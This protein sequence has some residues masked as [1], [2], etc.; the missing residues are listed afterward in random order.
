MRLYW[1]VRSKLRLWFGIE[2]M[3]GLVLFCSC[4][5]PAPV[6]TIEIAPAATVVAVIPASTPV[7]LA[8]VDAVPVQETRAPGATPAPEAMKVQQS[9]E[10]IE[11]EAPQAEAEVPPAAVA[12]MPAPT[13]TLAPTAAPA[14]QQQAFDLFS[15]QNA[16]ELGAIMRVKIPRALLDEG[17]SPVAEYRVNITHTSKDLF[18]CVV[19]VINTDGGANDT[20]VPL[21][22][23][24]HTGQSCKL[25]DFFVKS[26]LS[27]K[28]LLPDLVTEQAQNKNL[29]LLCEVPPVGEDQPFYIKDG[30]I[31]LLYRPYEIT[32]YEAGTPQFVLRE[33]DIAPYLSGAYGIGG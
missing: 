1:V 6:D 9:E 20:L 19:E 4:A 3:L 33:K 15:L 21:T 2:L 16:V 31:V 17:I 30:K 5:A 25:S 23:D 8:V 10:A 18:S 11:A 13:S 24:I 32:T 7:A 12:A 26:D 29:T 22:V 14:E 28:G 27:W